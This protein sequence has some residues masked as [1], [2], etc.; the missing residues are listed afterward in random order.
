MEDGEYGTFFPEEFSV[1]PYEDSMAQEYFPQGETKVKPPPAGTYLEISSL[2]DD[3]RDSDV[4]TIS[5]NA[6]LCPETGKLFRFQKQELDFYKKMN[7]PVP[8]VSFE[9]RYKRRNQF[10]PFP[11]W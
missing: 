10:V 3:I 5:K 1:F 7:L 9:A 8:H 4:E 6:Y 11:T 2:P